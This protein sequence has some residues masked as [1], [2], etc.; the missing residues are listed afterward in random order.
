[1]TLQ[2]GKGQ[3][4]TY[5]IHVPTASVG[6]YFTLIDFKGMKLGA[7]EEH[8][9]GVNIKLAL[10][11]VTAF[12]IEVEGTRKP[13]AVFTK[14][15]AE[16]PTSEKPFTIIARMKNDGNTRIKAEGR[17][18]MMDSKGNAAGWIKFPDIKTLPGD[19]REVKASWE[20]P[21]A[22]GKYKMVGTFELSSGGFM[23]KEQEIT[24]K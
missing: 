17:I 13:K 1:M 23:V 3:D 4:V 22:P 14:F 18:A 6:D 21:L 2:P 19:D 10:H 11:M 8:K 5:S 20:A 24:I 16:D 9:S 12:A 7:E 15:E